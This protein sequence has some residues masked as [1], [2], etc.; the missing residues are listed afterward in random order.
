MNVPTLRPGTYLDD[1]DHNQEIRYSDFVHKELVRYSWAHTLRS[2]PSMVDGLK[3][4]Q[5][6]YFFVVSKKTQ[7]GCKCSAIKCY[8][9]EHSAYR[10]GEQSLADTIIGMAQKYVGT[11]NIGFLEPK[12][13]F[14]TRVDVSQ[15]MHCPFFLYKQSTH[16]LALIHIVFLT[17][18][19]Y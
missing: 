17:S 16:E 14:G 18:Y 12:G 13:Q 19:C 4:D 11:N 6:K 5:R 3:P 10:H 2:I 1:H 7:Q 15:Q 8:V 9:S